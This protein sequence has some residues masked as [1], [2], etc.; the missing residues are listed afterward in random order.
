MNI[1]LWI[2]QG[3]LALVFVMAGFQKGFTP[4]ERLR[5]SMAAF[6]SL[7]AGLIRRFIGIAEIL[8]DLDS[9]FPD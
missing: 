6:N 9:Y 7:P 5:K 4:L 8:G 2:I 1:T 3:L